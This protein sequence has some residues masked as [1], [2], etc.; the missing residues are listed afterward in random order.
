MVPHMRIAVLSSNNDP[1]TRDKC[2]EL[3]ADWVFDKALDLPKLVDLLGTAST[4]H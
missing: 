3:G 2:M 4:L 1:F